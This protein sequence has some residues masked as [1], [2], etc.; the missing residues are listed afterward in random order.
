MACWMKYL[1]SKYKNLSSDS[2]NPHTI[3]VDL[4]ATCNPS[5]QEV[6]TKG[7]FGKLAYLA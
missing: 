5:S 2:Q 1:L 3:C 4:V 6:E 7:T